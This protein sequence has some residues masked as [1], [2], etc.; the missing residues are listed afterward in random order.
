MT[1][2]RH[3]GHTSDK[4]DFAHLTFGDISILQCLFARIDRFLDKGLNNT[5]ELRPA[6]LHIHVF[7]TRR[8]HRDV[9]QV[10]FRL[11][12]CKALSD[13]DLSCAVVMQ[14]FET[15]FVKDL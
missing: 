2:L 7:G 1:Y 5:F 9:W 12:R 4:D 6:Q 14:D 3:S 11:K 10:D 15:P 13:Q 8:V